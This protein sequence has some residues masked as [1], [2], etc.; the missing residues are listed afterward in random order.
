MERSLGKL[1]AILD[2]S[3]GI[4]SVEVFAG[5]V[6]YQVSHVHIFLDLTDLQLRIQIEHGN[7]ANKLAGMECPGKDTS[8]R[9]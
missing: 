4:V 3:A 9:K 6:E 5:V 1:A 8:S 2:S 7:D